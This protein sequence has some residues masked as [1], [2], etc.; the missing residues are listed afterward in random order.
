[1][2]LEFD[3]KTMNIRIKRR[4]QYLAFAVSLVLMLLLL[5]TMFLA[6]NHIIDIA[7]SPSFVLQGI[8]LS[9]ITGAIVGFVY[10]VASGW[11]FLGE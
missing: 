1:M 2:S 8:T 11:M 9:I 6:T 4:A 10:Y 7:V 5:V 3:R